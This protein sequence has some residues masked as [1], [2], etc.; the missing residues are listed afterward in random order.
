MM[1]YFT[2]LKNA[3]GFEFEGYIAKV[4]SNIWIHYSIYPPGIHWDI[5]DGE[6][7]QLST[8]TFVKGIEDAVIRVR[9]LQSLLSKS[10]YRAH[11]YAEGKYTEEEYAPYKA[12]R[13]AWRDE[14][15]HYRDLYPEEDL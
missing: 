11:K 14:I 12:E 4:P 3:C 1:I 2:E 6:F 8:L 5:I 9:E 15:N 10:D 13:Q 7:V